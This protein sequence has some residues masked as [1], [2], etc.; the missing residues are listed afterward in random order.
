MLTFRIPKV[1]R[2][3]SQRTYSSRAQ[4]TPLVLEATVDDVS[5]CS[6]I[7][8][9]APVD[10]GAKTSVVMTGGARLGRCHREGQGHKEKRECDLHDDER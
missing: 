8:V 3:T 2:D 4:V 10:T 7:G 1:S 5:L 9:G 6:R